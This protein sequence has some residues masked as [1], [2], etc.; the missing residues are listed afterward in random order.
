MHPTNSFLHRWAGRARRWSGGWREELRQ[1]AEQL[2]AA[3]MREAELAAELADTRRE[4][5]AVA[6]QL[7]AAQAEIG[8]LGHRLTGT[9]AAAEELTRQLSAARTESGGLARQLAA[10]QA[11]I[12]DLA[13]KL[14]GT[15][16]AAE[17]LM[18]QLAAARTD[19]A[20]ARGE[21]AAIRGPARNDLP[22]I[23]SV[24]LPKSGTVF[25]TALFHAGLG[26]QVAPVSL[27]Y[28]PKDLLDWTKLEDMRR[29]GIA[30]P[31]HIDASPANLQYLTAYAQPVHLHLRDPR[32]ATLS[33]T[34]HMARYQK[35]FGPTHGAPL[36]LCPTTPPTF[37]EWPLAEQ[38]GWMIA[39][40]LPS[41]VTW[42]RDWL[43]VYDAPGGPPFPILL[44]TFEEMI[45]DE[46]AVIRRILDFFGI[47]AERFTRPPV[48]KT[49]DSH[50]RQGTPDEWRSVYTP[51]QQDEATRQLPAE[52]VARFGWDH[53][54]A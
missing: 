39:N 23:L 16:A 20:A 7:A 47:P 9:T 28:F 29:G 35:K 33:M 38:I 37:H 1:T 45:R 10:A 14:A 8:G 48:A 40:Y 46:A 19:E 36:Q 42:V 21:L 30:V 5:D 54:R 22:S 15:T 11:E 12:G 17:E 4:A 2:S 34:H 51:A 43:A 25:L 6:R 31:S 27:T 32:Q 52:W 53:A 41:C 24:T 13:F 26:H 3:R 50:F 44:T 49:M 18:R